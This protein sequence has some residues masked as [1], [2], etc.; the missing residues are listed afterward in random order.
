MLDA[1]LYVYGGGFLITAALFGGSVLSVGGWQE[2]ADIASFL[3]QKKISVT[4]MQ[5][6]LV[7]SV[8]IWPLVLYMQMRKLW[9]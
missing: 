8:I 7:I 1:I 5:W 4:V 2:F 6:S 9:T 3:H